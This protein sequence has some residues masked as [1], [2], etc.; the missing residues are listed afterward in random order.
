VIGD[1][2][3]KA[4]LFNVRRS[5][6]RNFTRRMQKGQGVAQDYAQATTWFRK[7]TDAGDAG[8]MFQLGLP[9]NI[10]DFTLGRGRDGAATFLK[11]F[12]QTPV[13]DAYG[14]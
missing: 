4:A 6:Q 7:A 14:G 1:L 5:S 9:Y 3:T 10:F 11:N 2:I 12:K 8:A 13:A